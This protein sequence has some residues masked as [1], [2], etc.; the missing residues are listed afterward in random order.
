MLTLGGWAVGNMAVNAALLPNAS[1][2]DRYFYQMNLLWNTVNL[3]LAGVGFYSARKTL[4]AK[5]F[6]YGALNKQYQIEKTLL[7]NAGLDI[8]YMAF[9]AYL[10]ERDGDNAE[11]WEG[12][13]KGLLLQGGFLFVF[14]A[15]WYLVHVNHRKN[16]QGIFN[17]MQLSASFGGLRLRF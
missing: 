2:V 3:G 13:G 15:V 11:R 8:G 9:G 10:M 14:D 16:N 5:Q 6:S 17:K 1:G 12:F 4:P 7:F